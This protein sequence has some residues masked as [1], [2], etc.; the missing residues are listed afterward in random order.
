MGTLAIA[1]RFPREALMH[2]FTEEME[3]DMPSNC[4]VDDSHV[5]SGRNTSL[6]NS[7]CLY[8]D[9]PG[10]CDICLLSLVRLMLCSIE[11]ETDGR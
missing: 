3:T 8:P 11:R 5:A 6:R 1:H 2:P 10:H 9:G 4:S 7:L